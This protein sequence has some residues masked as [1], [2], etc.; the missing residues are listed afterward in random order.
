MSFGCKCEVT[1]SAT[2]WL[3]DIVDDA[4]QWPLPYYSNSHI[5]DLQYGYKGKKYS[6]FFRTKI[7]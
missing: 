6:I 1:H 7:K 4:D 2:N 3:Y 5:I